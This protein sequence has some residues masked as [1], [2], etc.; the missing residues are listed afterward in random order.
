MNKGK[1]ITILGGN[2]YVGKHCISK[3]LQMCPDARI[4]SI[5]RSGKTDMGNYMN[6]LNVDSDLQ[7]IENIKGS[8]SNKDD[9]YD[10]VM[11][12]DS[13]IHAI[14][15][16]FTLADNNKDE[17]YYMKQQKTAEISIDILKERFEKEK[18]KASFVFI[19]AERGLGFPLSLVFGG[20]INTKKAVENRLLSSEEFLNPY[21]LRPGVVTDQEQ[22]SWSVPLYH[23]VNLV[24]MIE[25]QVL[26]K[27][28]PEIG[29]KLQ[30]PSVGTK[31]EDL[32]NKAAE[33]ALSGLE[34]NIYNADKI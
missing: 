16:L 27:I 7:R 2:G 1:T 12:S 21:I 10:A 26:N 14:G 13:V 33:A 28:S 19:S 4:I 17:S 32:A 30:L 24:N 9:V 15:T 11:R 22:R 8:A 3:I 29:E 18:A 34:T 31:L 23:S 25:K 6:K 20:Y 5:S